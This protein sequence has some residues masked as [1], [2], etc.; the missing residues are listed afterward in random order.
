MVSAGAVNTRSVTSR[1]G[2]MLPPMPPRPGSLVQ[3]LLL[4]LVS[5]LAGLLATPPHSGGGFTQSYA[6]T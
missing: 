4:L 1:A 5:L 2:C 3:V 6:R